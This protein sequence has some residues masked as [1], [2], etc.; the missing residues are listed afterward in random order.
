MYYR[1][2]LKMKQILLR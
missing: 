1:Q 2:K